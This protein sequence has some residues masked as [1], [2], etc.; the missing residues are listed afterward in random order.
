MKFTTGNRRRPDRSLDKKLIITADD[1][2][3][4]LP[5]NEAVEQAHTQGILNTAS[6]M[7][8]EIAAKDAVARAKRLPSL[9]IGLH[10]TLVCGKPVLPAQQIPDLVGAEGRFSC[11]LVR[12]GFSFFFRPRVRRQLAAE[13]RAQFEAF[14]AT[15]LALDH[16]NAHHH[17]HLHPTV[18]GLILKIG[19]NYGLPAVRLP[20]EPLN[21]GNDLGQGARLER[22]VTTPW[23]ALMR[24]RLR[25]A[26]VRFNDYIF[27]LQ[28]TGHM[29]RSRV[30][31]LLATLPPGVSELF[32][33]P[34][35]GPWEGINEDS[36]SDEYQAELD[37]LIDPD[38]V[39]TIR[40]TEVELISFRQL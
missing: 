40:R 1:F 27:G 20:Y 17:M 13:I 30:L 16:V 29:N 26:G 38:V 23:I 22:L 18:M 8:G 28:D 11:D 35:T 21:D 39:S 19:A 25:R 14:Q 3:L 36:E 31:S 5:I 15:G 34:A 7:V 9:N 33:H 2:G 32:F 12:R 10:I 37:A 24:R 4:S 6:L